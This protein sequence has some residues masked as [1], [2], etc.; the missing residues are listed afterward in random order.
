MFR[1]RI[2]NIISSLK[3]LGMKL[4][5]TLFTGLI[6]FA[7]SGNAQIE[8]RLSVEINIGGLTKDVGLLYPWLY[9]YSLTSL[10]GIELG[11]ECTDKWSI[12][13]RTRK[14]STESQILG[15]FVGEDFFNRGSEWN[16]GLEFI[17]NKQRRLYLAYG[18]ELFG[19]F[20][21]LKGDF[22][23]DVFLGSRSVNHRKTYFGIAPR[24][25][26]NFRLSNHLVLTA[27]SRM[28]FGKVILKGEEV[29]FLDNKLYPDEEY[30]NHSFD[31]SNFLGIRFEF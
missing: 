2:E 16:L 26:I 17:P 20:S 14:I 5:I 8:E 3:I 24:L 25:K 21:K 19:E 10:N 4:K 12:H 30:W 31:P 11:Y 9:N 23:T 28:R 1:F 15:G 27:S 29:P 7:L 6:L 13:V 18:L 22:W